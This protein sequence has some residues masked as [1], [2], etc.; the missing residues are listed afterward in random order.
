M[1]MYVWLA[2]LLLHQ[3]LI[4]LCMYILVYMQHTTYMYMYMYAYYKSSI[5][6]SHPLQPRPLTA[7][8][9]SDPLTH[10]P[11]RILRPPT[12]S[13]NTKVSRINMYMY[14]LYTYKYACTC[15][16][17]YNY[18]YMYCTTPIFK[19]YIYTQFSM[20]SSLKYSFDSLMIHVH[21]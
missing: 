9:T 7:P 10:P 20:F 1:Y 3:I 6:H 17:M 8:P 4:G 18:M 14:V 16:C 13:T 11:G 15:T 5:H 21:V 2:R 12:A 19:A